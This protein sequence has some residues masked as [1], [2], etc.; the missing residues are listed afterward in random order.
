[1]LGRADRQ[2]DLSH[3]AGDGTAGQQLDG[4][5]PGGTI[6]N[7]LREAIE[8]LAFHGYPPSS[9]WLPHDCFAASVGW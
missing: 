5:A 2:A 8:L 9:S 1:V 3:R 6:A 4:R 7:E